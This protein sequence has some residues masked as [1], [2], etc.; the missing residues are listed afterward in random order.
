MRRNARRTPRVFSPEPFS[1]EPFSPEPFSPGALSLDD[2]S[3][4]SPQPKSVLRYEVCD[5]EECVGC[6][7]LSARLSEPCRRLQHRTGRFQI[8]AHRCDG[9]ETLAIPPQCA[10]ICPVEEAIVNQ[11]GLPV[12]P[13][14]SLTGVHL[15]R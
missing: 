15:R 3:P 12:N 2:L 5:H 14:G 8:H 1:P 7:R 6:P 10:T 13:K 11:H 4:E 9:C